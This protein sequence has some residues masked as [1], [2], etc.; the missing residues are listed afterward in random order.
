[1][2]METCCTGRRERKAVWE[3]V[4]EEQL[5]GWVFGCAVGTLEE[6]SS[7]FKTVSQ[8]YMQGSSALPTCF[9]AS[10]FK[11]ESLF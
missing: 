1:M 8:K 6:R 9:P 3:E 7:S 5:K 4:G 10:V 11:P 2:E